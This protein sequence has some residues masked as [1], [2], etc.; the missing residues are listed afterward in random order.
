[1]EETLEQKFQR[2]KREGKPKEENKLDKLNNQ[3][4]LYR[5]NRENT[6]KIEEELYKKNFYRNVESIKKNVQFFFWITLISII[7]T[8]FFSLITN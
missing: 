1:M 4:E 5:V 3:E 7:I 8:V 2:E 6:I